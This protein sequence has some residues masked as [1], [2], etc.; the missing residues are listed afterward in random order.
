TPPAAQPPTPTQVPATPGH[1]TA[2]RPAVTTSPVPPPP[3]VRT[4][5]A[6]SD[7]NTLGGG[8]AKQGCPACSGGWLI[9]W[10]GFNNTL[11]FNAV[12]S[13]ATGTAQVTVWYVNGDATRNAQVTVD[14]V[15]GGWMA[16]PNTGDWNTVGSITITIPVVQGANEIRFNNDNGWAPFFDKITVR[17]P[18]R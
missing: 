18:A 14:G 2:H 3:L 17:P 12:M 13:P 10:V 15:V 16:F 9:G 1:R 4:Y 8:A 5:E 6:E 11:Q 7:I